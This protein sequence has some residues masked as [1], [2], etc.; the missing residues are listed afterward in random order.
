[1]IDWTRVA[2]L[3]EEVGPEDFDEVVELFLQEVD[4][5]MEALPTA[6]GQDRLAGKLHFLKGSALSLGFAEFSNLCQAGE[7]NL[8]RDP[9]CDIDLDALRSSYLS[10]RETFLADLPLRLTG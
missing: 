3:R 8:K 2:A 4:E 5:E 10:S 1:V 6:G 7:S 9:A